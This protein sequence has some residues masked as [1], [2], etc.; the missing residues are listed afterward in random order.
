VTVAKRWPARS[1]A[2][3]GTV[4]AAPN[5]T[6]DTADLQAKLDALNADG[7]GSLT[8][9]A[10]TYIASTLTIYSNVTIRGQGVD[11]TILLQK[12]GTNADFVVSEGFAALEGTNG[13]ALTGTP[14][15]N[16]S[17]SVLGI[18]GYELAGFTIDGNKANNTSGRGLC[19]YGY[20]GR[21]PS[22]RIRNCA[23]M[24]FKHDWRSTVGIQASRLP[25]GTNTMQ[26]LVGELHIVGCNGGG[27][28]W[29]GPSDTQVLNL[30]A[31]QNGP[32]TNSGMTGWEFSGNATAGMI[33]LCHV[34]GAQ[35]SW[36]IVLSAPSCKLYDFEAEG[37]GMANV[38][39]RASNAFLYDFEIFN[40]GV[41]NS[42][43]APA[44]GIQISGS[45]T[46][47]GVTYTDAGSLG[48]H[49]I[50]GTLTKCG[51]NLGHDGGDNR[52][53]LE[54]YWPDNTQ[55]LVTGNWSAT[56]SRVDIQ[57][58]AGAQ[59]AFGT[60]VPAAY[61]VPARLSQV[62]R[63]T[64]A[65]RAPTGYLLENFRGWDAKD[66]LGTIGDGV[67]F[68][69]YAGRLRPLETVTNVAFCSGNTAGA[70]MTDCWFALLDATMGILGVTAEVGAAWAAN[71][72]MPRALAA[73][74]TAPAD[75][76]VYAGFL[77]HG[78]T[79]P[80]LRGKFLDYFTSA[81]PVGPAALAPYP[82]GTPAT[83]PG[84]LTTPA[85]LTSVAAILAANT[86]Q[87]HPWVGLS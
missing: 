46:A 84:A 35:H 49:R 30:E 16:P 29:N 23:G 22:L 40:G 58:G 54:S 14:Y 55:T 17:S 8:L 85:S 67:L 53:E 63:R 83:T 68:V 38:Y 25:G 73:P 57:Q 12:A 44:Y 3:G 77:W 79:A 71:T 86:S 52:I 82:G 4:A 33:L 64:S 13:G 9:R 39:L 36:G 37:A 1:P 78:G 59:A 65:N 6:D 32:S 48:G 19:I 28:K 61:K 18:H 24:G 26:C 43:P 81:A 80:S 2:E 5:G 70:G 56:S 76:D 20:A 62:P 34:W 74:Y 50:H 87:K 45:S 60:P 21:I 11:A 42:G 72:V 10:G 27:G 66:D 47:N 41:G 75:L 31:A 51:L 7:G 69:V 15:D